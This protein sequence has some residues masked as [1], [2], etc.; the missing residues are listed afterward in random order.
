MASIF[1][2]LQIPYS[3]LNNTGNWRSVQ[4]KNNTGIFNTPI[5]STPTSGSVTPNV[6]GM[7]LKDAVYLLEN[8]GLLVTA[9]GRGKVINQ[10]LPPGTNF[11]KKQNISLIL[12]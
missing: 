12:N 9:T 11:S 10:S 8:K 2:S 6:V 7:G 3:D 5:I 1:T 4:L